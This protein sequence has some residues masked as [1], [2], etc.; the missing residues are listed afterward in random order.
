LALEGL[1]HRCLP[2]SGLSAAIVAD[3]VPGSAGSNPAHYVVMNNTLYF[4]ANDGVHGA[5]L[6]KSDGTAAGT[7]L[8]KDINSGSGDSNPTD[9]TPVGSTLYFSADDGVHGLEL[10]KT[11]GSAAGTVL[12]KDINP[13]SGSSTPG[14][15]ADIKGTLFFSANDGVHGPELWKGNGTAAGTVLVKDINSGSGGS[16]PAWLTNVNG[17]AF[18]SADDAKNGRELWKSDGTPNG[19]KLVADIFP[20]DIYIYHTCLFDCF[21]KDKAQRI[22]LGTASSGPSWLTNVNGTLFFVAADTQ[23]LGGGG[24]PYLYKSDGTSGGTRRVAD[25]VAGNSLLNVNGTVFFSGGSYGLWKSDGTATGTVLV[26]SSVQP[27][28][29]FAS[30]NGTVFFDGD[31]F[32]GNELWK[33]DGTAA[34]TVLVKDIYPGISH[35]VFNDSSPSGLTN[36]NGLLYFSA[37]DG[38]SGR[39]L[40]QSDGTDAGTV[41]VQDVNPG[42]AASDPQDLV[43]MNNKLYFSADD[44]DHG[45]ELWDPPVVLGPLVQASGPSPFAG[46]TADNAAS[47]P[48]FYVP[49]T[50]VEP[51]VAVNPTNPKNVVATWQQDHWSNAAGRGIG[52]GVSF[53]GG[54]TWQEV[55]I[56]GITL[57]SGGQYQRAG[58]TWLS[59]APNG[60][61][62]ESTLAGNITQASHLA[63]KENAVLV[64]KSTDGGLTWGN[65]IPVIQDGNSDRFDDKDSITADPT[66]SNLVYA[67]WER[68][69]HF[70]PYVQAVTKFVRSTDGGRT[71]EAPRD[72][73]ASPNNDTN[74]G[75]QILVR[76]DGTLID[77]FTEITTHGSG[78]A[79]Q[80]MAL[81][82]TDKGLT[83][84]APIPASQLLPAGAIDPD[85]GQGIDDAGELAHY[86]VDPGNGNLYAVWADGRFSNFQYN[87]IAFAMSTD[88]G[89]TWSTPI[90]VNQT[91]DTIPAANRQALVPSVA[92]AQDGTVAV[93]Y[94]DFRNN[95]SAAGVATDY[96][97]VHA[98]PQ[99]GLTNPSS[100]REENRLTNVSFDFEQ[101]T[102]R[103]G[104][105]F[106]GDYEGLAAAGNSFYAV[107]TQPHDGDQDS[108]FFRDPPPADVATEAVASS[109]PPHA[110]AVGSHLR[111]F[112]GVAEG[113]VTGIDP[114]GA[115]VIA[116]TGYATHLGDFTRTEYVYFGPGGA[117]SGT[118]VFTAA[119]GDQLWADFSGEFTSPTTLKGTYTFTGGT[120][121]FSDATG[122]ASFEAISLDGIH[123][124]VSFD[125]SI[126]Y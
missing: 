12:V 17:V 28:G 94:Y 68:V 62:Y 103:F 69:N 90:R 40:W 20:G 32:G 52:A 102:P 36:V 110:P 33:S 84:S 80:L 61:L 4:A 42:S 91:P 48:G 9:L 121:R 70:S 50:E 35:D 88:G 29:R 55:V 77:L 98:H 37:D 95:T 97:M 64:S 108:I 79:L 107:W 19:T 11:D 14:A 16:G 15:M 89:L 76:P 47:Q 23:D 21:G 63:P 106:I 66:N 116:S 3:I 82:S 123:V 101:A 43:A 39:E 45:R 78:T 46:S 126:S 113:T 93:T 112:K 6:Y 31:G 10:W 74:T 125:G 105:P 85:T 54:L 60:D 120:G 65:P 57:V 109:P 27:G 59:F 81:R 2:A 67:V 44:G 119:N 51:Y 71:W 1:E 83:W 5:E 25:V 118:V 13:G 72:I 49:D 99:N 34:G 8:V 26:T 38:L 114:S 41:M 58:D 73:F 7:V 96:W 92:V 124:A 115:I 53:D 75:H 24:I 117:I 56:P 122:T 86:A 22:D 104:G 30:V 18:F 87:S 100:W 111:P